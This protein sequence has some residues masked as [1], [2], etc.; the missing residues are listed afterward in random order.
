[1]D[2]NTEFANV[3]LIQ[4]YSVPDP[5]LLQCS[6]HIMLALQLTDMISVIH[7]KQITGVITMIPQWMALPSG[8]EQE[9]YCMME[10]LPYSVYREADDDDM[11]QD[12]E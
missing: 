11:G 7:V 6:S 4:M 5:E 10:H 12:I 8:M 2:E 1:M 3:A 9:M